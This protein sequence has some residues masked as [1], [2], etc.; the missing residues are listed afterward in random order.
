MTE[1]IKE[2]ILLN[3][4]KRGKT[5]ARRVAGD[6]LIALAAAFTI[7]LAV[8]MTHRINAVVLKDSYV[9]IFRYEMIICGVF[10]LLALDIRFGFLTK[11]NGF[12]RAAG[13]AARILLI[14]VTAAVLFFCGK[15]TAGSLIRTA[16]SAKHA[17]VLGLALEDGRPTDDLLSR[18]DTARQYLEE[19]PETTLILTGGNA[20]EPGRTEAEVMRDLLAEQGVPPEKMILEDQAETTKENFRNVVRMADPGEPVVLITSDYHMDR[21]A[22][23]AAD[24]GFTRVT[25]LPAKSSAVYFGA[26]V[27]WETILE[28]N[29]LTLKQE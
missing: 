5:M 7:Y 10:L 2:D 26:N 23:T 8:I 25:R 19:N 22:K 9:K 1:Q 14:F 3:C 20:A 17:L 27:M 21:A 4:G 16:E 13:W 24:A 18:L 11:G 29:E 15:I 12:L 6:L 28:L